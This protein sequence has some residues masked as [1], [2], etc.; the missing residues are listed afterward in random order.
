LLKYNIIITLVINTTVSHAHSW[1]CR[2]ISF[3]AHFWDLPSC[4]VITITRQT[5]WRADAAFL[6]LHYFET[7]LK[8]Y[9]ELYC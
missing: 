7:D 8:S 9:F 6:L 5:I 3:L 4:T 1:H 2:W